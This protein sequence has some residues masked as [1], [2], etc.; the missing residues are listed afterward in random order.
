MPCVINNGVGLVA[1]LHRVRV[2]FPASQLQL[3][4]CGTA[5]K[6][7]LPHAAAEA[8]AM[9]VVARCNESSFQVQA[10]PMEL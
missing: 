10:I 7:G 2:P 3:D 4:E 9:C 1:C 5:E 8:A 6:A